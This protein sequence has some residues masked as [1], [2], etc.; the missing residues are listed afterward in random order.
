MWEL[1]LAHRLT[2]RKECLWGQKGKQTRFPDQCESRKNN[3]IQ[4][5]KLF[6]DLWGLSLS[7]WIKNWMHSA[8]ISGW[9][10]CQF[11]NKENNFLFFQVNIF[12]LKPLVNWF[13]LPS[14]SKQT[15]G[16]FFFSH[17]ALFFWSVL[18]KAS[19]TCIVGWC[20]FIYNFFAPYD[21][22]L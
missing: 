2:A 4:T 18:L 1:W 21:S 10:N 13:L 12:W 22:K 14:L 7:M 9:I 16:L 5:I 8:G 17:K 20:V 6:R 19:A 3:Q 15:T 11:L